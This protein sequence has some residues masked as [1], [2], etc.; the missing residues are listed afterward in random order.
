VDA[1]DRA[2]GQRDADAATECAEG[3]DER[4]GA[5]ERVDAGRPRS[6]RDPC[7]AAEPAEQQRLDDE[8]GGD[9]VAA[10]AQGA[11]QAARARPDGG[12]QLTVELAQGE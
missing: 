8:L 7:Q 3:D 1:R 5:R 6:E 9:V 10:G 4:M 2:D 12:L 11:A